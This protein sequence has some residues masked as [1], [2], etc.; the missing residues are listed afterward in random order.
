MLDK[1]KSCISRLSAFA[2]VSL[3]LDL[4]NFTFWVASREVFIGVHFVYI[5]AV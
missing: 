2:G 5:L 4:L 3:L 1:V